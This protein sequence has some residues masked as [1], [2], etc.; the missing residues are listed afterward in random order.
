MIVGKEIAMDLKRLQFW[1]VLAIILGAML[2]LYATAFTNYTHIQGIEQSLQKF[3]QPSAPSAPAATQSERQDAIKQYGLLGQ[4]VVFFNKCQAFVRKHPQGDPSKFCGCM[5]KKGTSEFF[6]EYK[7]SAMR[8]VEVLVTFKVVEIGH[9]DN[10]WAD[11]VK[12]DAVPED[13]MRS[14]RSN[15]ARDV[16]SSVKMCRDAAE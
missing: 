6:P 8:F 7:A 15:V 13:A 4:E 11:L 5:A 14:S 3:P 16:F 10:V 1:F 2:P 9:L 12:K